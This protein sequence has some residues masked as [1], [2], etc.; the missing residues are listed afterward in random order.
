M[1]ATCAIQ[2]S[3]HV[4]SLVRK[5]VSRIL[6]TYHYGVVSFFVAYKSM[7]RRKP[8][9]FFCPQEVRTLLYIAVTADEYEF[10][11]AQARTPRAL[12]DMLGMS[13]RQVRSMIYNTGNNKVR[14]LG[15]RLG[16]RIVR[17]DEEDE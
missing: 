11:I 5:Y 14:N 15:K 4:F 9:L 7:D 13:G 2:D 16:E 12:A 3:I 10:P 6:G 8:V 17:V 1:D